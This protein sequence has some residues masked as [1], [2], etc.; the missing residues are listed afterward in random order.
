LTTIFA[1]APENLTYA[2]LLFLTHC[3]ACK[4]GGEEPNVVLGPLFP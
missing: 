2:N 1:T 3:L 4:A